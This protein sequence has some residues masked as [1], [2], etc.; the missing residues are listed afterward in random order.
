MQTKVE[1]DRA[2]YK[3]TSPWRVE[4]LGLR[5]FSLEIGKSTGFTVADSVN[6]N[7]QHWYKAAEVLARA[8]RSWLARLTIRRESPEEFRCALQ[9]Q[10]DD[11]KSSFSSARHDC[12]E[13]VRSTFPSWGL[14]WSSHKIRFDFAPA[15]WTKSPLSCRRCFVVQNR[16]KR[17]N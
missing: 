7:K 9:R 16:R 10:R 8:D 5:S 1:V 11:I 17:Q 2:E 14:R 4:L 15:S 13:R 6:A 3:K 12:D